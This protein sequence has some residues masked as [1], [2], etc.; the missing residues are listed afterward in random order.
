V[1]WCVACGLEDFEPRYWQNLIDTSLALLED[2]PLPMAVKPLMEWETVLE[3]TA[4]E[5]VPALMV[6]GYEAASPR[7]LS[8]DLRRLAPALRTGLKIA[9]DFPGALAIGG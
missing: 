3:I 6:F 9:V 7:A 2:D 4:P 1:Q 5:L 8:A